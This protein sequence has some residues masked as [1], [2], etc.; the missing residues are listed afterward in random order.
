MSIK[1][2]LRP[3][4]ATAAFVALSAATAVAHAQQVLRL[5]FASGYPPTFLFVQEI[6]RNFAEEM[7]RELARK[8]NRYRIEW[9]FALAGTLAKIPGMLEAMET[10]QAE[11][12]HVAHLFAPGKLPLQNVDA[13]TPFSVPDHRIAA[14]VAQDLLRDVPAVREQYTRLGLVHLSD[15]ALDDYVIASKV[16]INAVADLRGRKV[17]GAGANLNWLQGTGAAGVTT[18]GAQAYTDLKNGV[19]DALLTPMSFLINAKY[20]E[21]APYIVK[22][23]F[24]ALNGGQIVANKA[25]FDKLPA[26]VRDAAVAAASTFRTRYTE[27]LDKALADGEKL[28]VS[29]GAKLSE[30]PAAERV[31]WAALLPDLA[32]NWA[33]ELDA[34][35]Q[36]ASAV[37]KAQM[38]AVRRAGV[39]P[40]RA[41]DR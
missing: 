10:G 38:A 33:R 39:E 27:A 12:G 9:N 28:I 34:K 24:N 11:F 31:R 5:T 16:P 30:L 35:G 20:H 25:A 29:Q 32:G 41:W 19:F 37:V 14:R 8:G 4:V 1:H 23:R 36:P 26:E 7:N 3:V 18:T 13:Y 17:G 6:Q 15:F 40:A 22:V 21:V 2:F